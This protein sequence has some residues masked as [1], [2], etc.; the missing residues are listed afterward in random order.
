[1]GKIFVPVWEMMTRDTKL[2]PA[3]GCLEWTGDMSNSGYGRISRN[4]VR[5]LAHRM[6]WILQNGPIPEALPHVCHHCDNRRCVNPKHLFLGT[7]AENNRD[8]RE[9]KRH[10]HGDSH[11]ATLRPRR[12]ELHPVARL[13]EEQVRSIRRD[14]RPYTTIMQEY[15]IK[16]LATVHQIKKR[17]TWRHV[18]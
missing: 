7:H 9:K 13:T 18:D 11:R 16:S 12:G 6:A 14:L 2:D 17:K 5:E 15:G 1:M 10:S 4:G 8:M 3:T